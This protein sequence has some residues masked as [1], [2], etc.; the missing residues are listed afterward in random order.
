MDRGE[1]GAASV[2]NGRGRDG[3]AK[4]GGRKVVGHGSRCRSEERVH[5]AGARR[6]GLRVC[7]NVQNAVAC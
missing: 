5:G 7:G 1:E 6:V 4:E 3:T 2:K